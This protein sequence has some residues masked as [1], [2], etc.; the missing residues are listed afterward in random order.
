[1]AL[2]SPEVHGASKPMAIV[3]CWNNCI[4]RELPTFSCDYTNQCALLGIKIR[5]MHS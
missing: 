1:M 5:L 3:L 2:E 4:G